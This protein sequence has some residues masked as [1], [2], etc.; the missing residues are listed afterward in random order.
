MPLIQVS[1]WLAH[2]NRKHPPSLIVLH[3]TAG[4]TASSSINHLRSVGL[5]YHYIIARDGRDSAKSEN[6]NG[7]AP[8]IF[9]CV[10]TANRAFHVGSQVPT[11]SGQGA[12]NETSIGVSLANIQ[13]SS[14]P[15]PYP[16]AQLAA[17]EDLIARIK[18]DNPAVRWLTTH[19]VV[20]PWNR[21]DPRDIDGAAIARR[22]GLTWWQPTPEQIA[23]HRPP[24][25]RAA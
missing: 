14:N 19:A 16:P 11:P 2:G 10:P 24:K 3:A 12:C 25:A 1:P 15:E 8:I 9:H 23:Q 20:Q 21:A 22:H 5:S 6:A 7:T 4:S 13:R 18:E 17:L